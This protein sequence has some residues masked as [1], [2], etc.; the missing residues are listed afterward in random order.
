AAVGPLGRVAMRPYWVPFETAW[1]PTMPGMIH[2]AVGW[3]LAAVTALAFSWASFGRV[4]W[5]W[6]ALFPV[7][8]L[9]GA[10]L[11][12]GQITALTARWGRTAALS[13]CTRSAHIY[14][15]Q[16]AVCLLMPIAA[17]GRDAW[18][19]RR[20]DALHWAGV[21]AWL[22]AGVM[23]LVVYDRYMSSPAPFPQLHRL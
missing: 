10:V 23:Q 22:V 11:A 19:G 2:Q 1:S 9:G 15:K 4:A 14:G 3:S 7:I 13:W 20:G 8:G 17:L 18:E 6:W 5:R 16:F 21:T 12:V